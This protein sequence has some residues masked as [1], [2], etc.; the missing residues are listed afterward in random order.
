MVRR[1]RNRVWIVY[2]HAAVMYMKWINVSLLTF[3]MLTKFKYV[4][5][6]VFSSICIVKYIN[7]YSTTN[8]S[9]M[10]FSLQPES[11][12]KI[13]IKIVLLYLYKVLYYVFSKCLKYKH[14]LCKETLL[15]HL[16]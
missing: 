1:Q 9:E 12:K 5:S 13:K 15:I 2:I 4:V 8:F 14:L 6:Y 3:E 11:T 10:H 16:I 7:Y